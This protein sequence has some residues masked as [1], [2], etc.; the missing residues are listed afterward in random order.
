MDRTY[1]KRKGEDFSMTRD[2][3]HLEFKWNEKPKSQTYD[4]FVVPKIGSTEYQSR[5]S[6]RKEAEKKVLDNIKLYEPDIS[7]KT[8]LKPIE[9][10]LGASWNPD[11]VIMVK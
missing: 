5:I 4:K 11:N 8:K 10:K 2:F 9:I 7:L 3:S 6:R 1:Q